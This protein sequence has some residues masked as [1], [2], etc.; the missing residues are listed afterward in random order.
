MADDSIPNPERPTSPK[1]AKAR[2]VKL[3]RK[4]K[5]EDWIAA[6]SAVAL[7]GGYQHPRRTICRRAHAGLI[8]ARAERFFRDDQES[9]NVE[10]PREF[11][12]AKG[13]DALT[14]GVM[15]SI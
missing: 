10:I 14:P 2:G 4:P 7:L 8:K 5:Q 9:D 11:W 13:E 15:P 12:W 6:H 1:R 3:G